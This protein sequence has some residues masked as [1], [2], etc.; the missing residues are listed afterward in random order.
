MRKG[1]RL[2]EQ[3]ATEAASPWWRNLC[4]LLFRLMVLH[5]DS[6]K[7]LLALHPE[8]SGPYDM[9]VSKNTHKKH[10]KHCSPNND[11]F[12][13]CRCWDC[14]HTSSCG[15][16]SQTCCKSSALGGEEGR[17]RANRRFQDPLGG[18]KDAQQM[19]YITVMH[20]P[21]WRIKID[22]SFKFQVNFVLQSVMSR[23]KAFTCRRVYG[24]IW[25][26]VS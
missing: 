13:K 19:C 3:P 11:T 4:W 8:V 17:W 2:P 9:Y 10:K 14:S 18:A 25:S 21:L 26:L 6:T 16:Y 7:W 1:L 23:F 12:H 22:L 24:L 5:R 15:K 20:A